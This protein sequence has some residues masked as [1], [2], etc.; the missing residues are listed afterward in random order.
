MVAPRRIHFPAT[1]DETRSLHAG[2]MVLVTG[3]IVTGRDKA[4]QY[5]FTERPGESALPFNLKGSLL[6]HCGPLVK[7][8]GPEYTIVA[9]GPTTSARMEMYQGWVI[10]RYGLCA[11]MGKGGMGKTTLEALKKTGAV[12]LQTIGGAAVVLA[13]KVKRVNGV[14][15]LE[16]FG[17]PE[18]MWVLEVENF[19]AVVTMDSH[20]TSVHESVRKDSE[21]TY[22]TLLGME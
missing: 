21:E 14:F 6:Y 3:R 22:R 11:V 18:A 17:M 8:E 13:E 19:P 10:E 9:C 12:Y 15:R 20:G 4:H 7:K 5:L 2:D 1:K 16:E